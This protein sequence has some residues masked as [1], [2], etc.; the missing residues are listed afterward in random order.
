MGL[1]VKLVIAT[2]IYS[3]TVQA[4]ISVAR[5]NSIANRNKQ[6]LDKIILRDAYHED[7]KFAVRIRTSYNASYSVSCN[8]V[9]LDSPNLVLSDMSCIKYQG[10]A[11]IDARHV[12]VIVSDGIGQ[13]TEHDVDQ[14]FLNKVNPQQDP[15]TEIALLRL[16]KPVNSNCSCRKI[17][18]PD[19]NSTTVVQ[20]TDV[21]VVGYTHNLDLKESR[22]RSIKRPM[23]ASDKYICT[24][25]AEYNETP[26]TKLLRGAPLISPISCT[27]F[28]LLGILTRVDSYMD[29]PIR[30]HQD[31]YLSVAAQMRWYNQVR[32]LADFEAKN[33]DVG[34]Q[35]SVVVVSVD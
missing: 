17:K 8:G 15:S 13:E 29:G 34:T 20:E 31:C 33:N 9:V 14:I 32:T 3:V 1:S 27:E 16:S 12:K 22:T 4:Q 5:R 21:R 7:N 30:K 24:V 28:K 26:G 10:L 35:P 18:A 25:P 23:T 2:L 11:N 6:Q 19:T